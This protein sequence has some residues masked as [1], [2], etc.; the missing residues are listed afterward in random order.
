M[1]RFKIDLGGTGA[2]H[3]AARGA[4]LAGVFPFGEK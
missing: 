4:A 2:L 1:C 3:S